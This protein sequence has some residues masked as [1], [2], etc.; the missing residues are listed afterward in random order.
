L[1]LQAILVGHTEVFF[2]KVGSHCVFGASVYYIRVIVHKDYGFGSVLHFPFSCQLKSENSQG[3]FLIS[4]L[5]L[6]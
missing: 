5:K 1:I 6:S 4:F 3:I 2:S